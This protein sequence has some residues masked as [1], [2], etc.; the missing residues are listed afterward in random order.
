MRNC[1]FLLC[2]TDGLEPIIKNRFNHENYFYTSLGNSF[3]YDSK[4]IACIKEIINTHNIKAIY[5]VLSADNQIILDALG[6]QDFSDIRGL[7]NFYKEITVQKEHVEETLYTGNLQ[8]SVLSYHLNKKIKKLELELY[9]L[10]N[11]SIKIRAKVYNRQEDL[12]LTIYSDLICLEKHH[13][14]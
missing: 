7:K 6:N 3:I 14:N 8:F 13:L 5:F 1:L 12:F 9:G 4:T 10:R 11:H 2:P